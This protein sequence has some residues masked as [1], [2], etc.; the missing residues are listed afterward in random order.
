MDE[1]VTCELLGVASTTV[2]DLQSNPS[3]REVW[4]GVRVRTGDGKARFFP[5]MVIEAEASIIL[6]AALDS[7]ERIELWLTGK[8]QRAHPYAIRTA[9]EE[10]YHDGYAG[11]LTGQGLKFLLI[12]IVTLPLLGMGIFGIIAAIQYFLGASTFSARHSR[13]VF[14]LGLPA[15]LVRRTAGTPNG[16]SRRAA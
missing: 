1:I 16:E 2:F 15:D 14:A 10:W 4:T 13:Q 9:I 6:Q 5:G 11:Y 12:G 8:A 3:G 7:G